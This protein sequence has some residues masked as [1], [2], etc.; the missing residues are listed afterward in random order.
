MRNHLLVLIGAV[1]LLGVG[2]CPPEADVEA[3]VPRPPGD[4][5]HKTMPDAWLT[6]LWAC[7]NK[8]AAQIRACLSGRALQEFEKTA[9]AGEAKA[10]EGL[11][12]TFAATDIVM[13]LEHFDT[14]HANG[15]KILERGT[16]RLI[17]I[18]AVRMENMEPNSLRLPHYKI[19]RFDWD[20]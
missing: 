2:A 10:V 16:G 5:G 11:Y 13:N 15:M 20:R 18:G 1:T 7:H 12:Q 19:A 14:R 9:A 4:Y 6:F 8:D 3:D 17:Q